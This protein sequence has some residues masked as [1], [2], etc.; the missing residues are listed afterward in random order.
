M[1]GASRTLGRSTR[2]L[3]TS[4]AQSRQSLQKV[5]GRLLLKAQHPLRARMDEPE[6]L[7]VKHRALRYER[8]ALEVA[9]VHALADH[10]MAVLAA[11]NPDLMLA[12]GRERALDQARV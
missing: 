4:C 10:R 5:F 11:V 3:P 9:D 12:P 8:R 6:C 7:G 1:R 2:D